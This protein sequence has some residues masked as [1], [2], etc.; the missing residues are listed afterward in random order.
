MSRSGAAGV[1]S[2]CRRWT[3]RGAPIGAA[4]RGKASPEREWPGEVSAVV[5][6][7]A[8]ADLNAAYRNFFASVAGRRKGPQPRR[9]R[10][11]SR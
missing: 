10:Y 6:Q 5:L 1:V 11:R 7:Q 4:D 3:E 8:L 9:P 2:M